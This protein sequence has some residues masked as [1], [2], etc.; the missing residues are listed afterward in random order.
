LSAGKRWEKLSL[1]MLLVLAV[2]GRLTVVSRQD[3]FLTLACRRLSHVS[4]STVKFST[5]AF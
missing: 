3:S 2:R 5:T 4:S 1:E